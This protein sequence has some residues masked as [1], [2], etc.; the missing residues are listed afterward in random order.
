MMAP[1]SSLSPW[2]PRARGLLA[3]A[4][5]GAACALLPGCGKSSAEA[6][7]TAEPAPPVVQSGQL[8]FPAGHPQLALLGTAEARAAKDV[9]VELPARLVWNE[10]RTQRI[11]PA[12][13]GRVTTM[14]ADL[15]QAVKAGAP[16]ALLASPD[17]GQAQADTAKA[18]ALQS[19][20]QQSLKRQRELFEAGIVARK[21]L[22]QAEADAAGA[23]AEVA[24]AAARTRL[25]GG[26]G[27]VN[28][29]LALTAGIGGVVVERNLNPG[30]EV[31]PDQSGP[32]LFVVTDPTSLWVQIDAREADLASLRPG[33]SFVLQVPAYPGTSF[34]G[35]VTATADAID[36]GSRTI[37]VRGVVPNADRRLKAEMLATARVQ[38]SRANG[39][40]VP[41]AAIVLDGTQHVVYVRR[42]AGVFEPRKVALAQEGPGEVIVASG[43]QAG[44]AVVNQNALLL[45][46]QFQAAAED[47]ALTKKAAP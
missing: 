37:K 41:A 2:R 13:A 28:Q 46:R 26:G 11:Y 19:L 12:F 15:G 23:R 8:R 6:P 9:A 30:Q 7:P 45:A 18:T 17:F 4:A 38:E 47:A 27:A 3:L 10:E 22:E 25:Y 31:R 29:Q 40:V 16:L 21:D 20:S 43:L 42:E 36:P 33:D 24:R 39:V 34:T 32:A 35:K 1:L 14:H 5:I 44:E